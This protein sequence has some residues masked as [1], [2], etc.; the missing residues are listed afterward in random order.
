MR[1]NDRLHYKLGGQ[2]RPY[3]PPHVALQRVLKSIIPLTQPCPNVATMVWQDFI[4]R[5]VP[6][7]P[8]RVKEHY[9]AQIRGMKRVW[10]ALRPEPQES[11][12][13]C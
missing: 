8:A 7:Q 5:M 1:M 4:G 9:A 6:Q 11:N 12:V 3:T 13:T 2:H 10:E